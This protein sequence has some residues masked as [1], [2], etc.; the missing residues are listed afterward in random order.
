MGVPRAVS[1]ATLA[2][3]DGGLAAT[4]VGAAAGQQLCRQRGGKLVA[5]GCVDGGTATEALGNAAPRALGAIVGASA[6]DRKLV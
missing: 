2:G 1:Q 4:E 6:Y 3:A 5:C